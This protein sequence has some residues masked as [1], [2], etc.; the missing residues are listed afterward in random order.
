MVGA[1]RF[2]FRAYNNTA[3]QVRQPD[4]AGILV[5]P[6]VRAALS[7]SSTRWTVLQVPEL[8]CPSEL[9]L[10]E[11]GLRPL[12]GIRQL[13]PDYLARMLRVEHDPTLDAESILRQMSD[14]GFAATLAEAQTVEGDDANSIWMADRWLL[15]AVGLLAAAIAL[16][17]TRSDQLF[18]P[19]LSLFAVIL[20]GVPVARNAWRA[21]CL[22]QLDMNALLT[23]A[24]IGAVATGQWLEAATGMVLFRI[25]LLIDEASKRKAHQSIRAL[26]QLSPPIAHLVASTN[27]GEEVLTDKD[28]DELRIGQM[29]RVR[30]GERVPVDGEVVRGESSVNE[31]SITGESQPRS[32]QTG[33]SVYAGSLNGEGSL[34]V[35]IG[36]TAENSTLARI[37]QLIEQA[38]STRSPTERFIDQFARIYTPAVIGFAI[39]LAS[40]PP[41][42]YVLATDHLELIGQGSFLA[43]WRNWFQ[44]ALVM[45]VIA[46]PCALVLST[47]IT[48]IC[49]LFNASR[50][51]MLVKGGEFLEEMGRISCLALDKTGTLTTGQVSVVAVHAAPGFSEDQVLTFAASLE[52]HS[53]HPLAQAV[54]DEANRR[55]CRTEEV[56]DFVSMRGLGVQGTI[57]SRQYVAGSQRFVRDRGWWREGDLT[58]ATDLSDATRIVV[59]T[60]DQVV[61]AI[62]LRDQARMG[63]KQTIETCRQLGV[64]RVIMLTGD[65]DAVAASVARD[66][67]IGDY[68]AELLPDDKI[69]H[70]QNLV[71]SGESVAMVGDGVNDAPALAAASIG[72]ALGSNASDTAMET[73]DVV[74]ISPNLQKIVALIQLSR[75]TRRIL[76][77]NIVFA[78]GVKL[79]VLGLAAAGLATLWMAVA[80]DVGASLLVIFN[81]T[82][83]LRGESLVD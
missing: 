11:S 54:V 44:R 41:L 42:M 38:Q 29:V 82:R 57:N 69:R 37:S 72:I 2:A 64:K 67:S 80:A 5:T 66:L 71:H 52:Q 32:K 3:D 21:V 55:G 78:L 62:S 30:P 50:Q 43:I 53:E 9:G 48:V 77:E 56:E 15:V 22:R 1:D 31:A 28:V 36:R 13:R 33:D 75:R 20:A 45:L 83:L 73:A 46:C 14:I 81:G 65:H 61:G 39:L 24:S 26:M 74:V 7:N 79:F 12:K 76:L 58:V 40:V 51:G 18:V 17:L 34:D 16:Q 49:G 68:H 8:D 25:S 59:A 23:L 60:A 10:I 4:L 6:A 35:R 19:L 70:V 63:A 27:S 47:P